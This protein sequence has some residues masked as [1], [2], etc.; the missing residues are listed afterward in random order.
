MIFH[1]NKFIDDIRKIAKILDEIENSP[2]SNFRNNETNKSID[3]LR[4]KHN[5]LCLKIN[6]VKDFLLFKKIFEKAQ[7]QDQADRFNDAYK[8]L[9]E[10]L[11]KGIV[12]V[13]KGATEL[14]N[15]KAALEQGQAQ[16]DNAKEEAM[17][18]ADIS[19]IVTSDMLGT[20]IIAQDFN[21]PAGYIEQGATSYL[22]TVGDS[23]RTVEDLEDMVLL[24]MGMEDIAPIKVKDVASVDILNNAD[25]S[26]SRI[27]GNPAV[28]LSIEKQTGYSTGE[29]TDKLLKRF[30]QLEEEKEG[31]NMAVLM[32]QGVYIDIVVESVLQNMLIGAALAVIVLIIFLKDF[33]STFIIAC[34]I[35]LS[36]VFAIV[37]MYFTKISLNI[38]SLSGIALGIGMLVDNSIVV[39]ENIYRLRKEGLTVKKAAVEGAKGVGGA[40][41][42]STLTTV[43]VF[44]PIV[45]SKGVTKQIF[46]DMALTVT[47]TLGASLLVAL[48][49][50]P[51]LASMM[52]KDGEVKQT[53]FFCLC[54][55]I[56]PQHT[57]IGRMPT[58]S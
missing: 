21:M 8:K 57:Q 36:V 7:G 23:V 32:N 4:D 24:D 18:A 13:S 54:L 34:S 45:F 25:E 2:I 3:E 17:K 5:D 56:I 22:V 33:K 30:K 26:Y 51:C 39:I 12:E 52:M 47:Y 37:L 1:R 44:A 27:N 15:G 53:K 6:E 58:R 55:R 10:G 11:I 9:N 29:V 48:T 49:F 43:C 42:A 31:L 20:L 46:I 16:L 41:A 14:A 38:I 19:A 35:P 40:I 28:M 50:V